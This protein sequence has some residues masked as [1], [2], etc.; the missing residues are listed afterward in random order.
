MQRIAGF[1]QLLNWS[2]LRAQG[3]SHATPAVLPINQPV[4]N[5]SR[6]EN[7]ASIAFHYD[8]SNQFYALWLDAKMV[9][10]CAYF[11]SE[12]D[13]LEQAQTQ[14]LDHICRKLLLRPGDYLLDIGCGWGALAMHAARHYGVKVHGITLSREQWEWANASVRREGLHHQIQIDLCDYRDL[15]GSARYD[16]ISSVGMFEHVGLRNLNTYFSTIYRLLKS[17]GLVLN[18]GITHEEEGW[19]GSL[20]SRFINRYVF[21]DGELDTVSN[22]QR[23]MEHCDFEIAD[24]E[25]LRQHYALTLRHW[26]KRL[27]DRRADALEHVSESTWRIWRLFMASSALEFESGEL[28]LYQILATKR[29][30]VPLPLPLTRRHLYCEI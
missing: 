1:V 17:N 11:E 27:E 14:K 5:H 29:D 20:S 13:T 9:Y 8:V 22:I 7:K 28:G 3:K 4:R 18:H 24:V 2:L 26:V 30:G 10:S 6:A 12:T 21:P 19:G 16:K 23:V 25:N 15:M